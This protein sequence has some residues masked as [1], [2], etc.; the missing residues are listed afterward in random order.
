MRVCV[1][2]TPP[3]LAIIGIRTAK[4]ITCSKV[5]LKILITEAA[6][7][8][9]TKLVPSQNPLVL[10]AVLVFSKVSLSIPE[11]CLNDSSASDLI[12]S[13]TSSKVILPMRL[14]S[15]SVTGAEIKS[16]FSKILI[17]SEES[18]L[19][20]IEF[21]SSFIRSFT[22]VCGELV[23][24]LERG[25]EPLNLLVLL[26]TKTLSVDSGIFFFNLKYLRTTSK[27]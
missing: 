9:V 16:F 12:S 18:V 2:A 10:I 7:K 19:I 15:S 11:I 1:A 3:I 21:N 27:V 6:I 8:A 17:T 13:I 26:T 23:N 24:I 5:S 4:K 20:F 14:F 22:N 25:R